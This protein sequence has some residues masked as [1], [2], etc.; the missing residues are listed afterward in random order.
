MIEVRNK[1]TL[2][3]LRRCS[4]AVYLEAESTASGNISKKLWAAA[5]EI[6]WLRTQNSIL[7]WLIIAMNTVVAGSFLLHMQYSNFTRA[8]RLVIGMPATA[9]VSSSRS[10][11]K[12][13]GSLPRSCKGQRARSPAMAEHGTRR[14]LP[15][16]SCWG[17]ARMVE[18]PG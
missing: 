6:E 17:A 8:I 3:D 13:G 16:E 1:D 15:G 10:R 11:P 12:L 5:G 2:N 14:P 18:T 9:P 4:V 7:F